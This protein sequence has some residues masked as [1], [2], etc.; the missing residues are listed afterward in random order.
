MHAS[1]QRWLPL[2]PCLI[3]LCLF[4]IIPAQAGIYTDSYSIDAKSGRM[5]THIKPARASSRVGQ[6][7]DNRNATIWS[8]RLLTY[9]NRAAAE[10]L[11]ARLTKKGF[12]S[13]VVAKAGGSYQVQITGLKSSG[14]AIAYRR[15]LLVET[16]IL[17][18]HIH[19]ASKTY[20]D[21]KRPVL[22]KKQLVSKPAQMKHSPFQVNRRASNAPPVQPQQKK[23]LKAP[24]IP[25]TEAIILH[26]TLNGADVGNHFI[27]QRADGDFL[28]TK[29]MLKKIGLKNIPLPQV[30]DNTPLSL[31][32]IHA[33]MSYKMDAQSG[34]LALMVNPSLLP[35]TDKRLML[36]KPSHAEFIQD[37]ALFLNY[38]IGYQ[39]S[40]AAPGVISA[41]FELG[42]N[43]KSVSLV[44]N[45]IYQQ[46][47]QLQRTQ[48]QLVY[49][50][51]D[52]LQRWMA[53]DIFA[54]SGDRIGGAEIG[55]ISLSRNYGLKPD[56]F[57]A[58]PLQL[59][60]MLT[61]ASEVEVL[62]DG[63]SIYKARFPAGKL[64][65]SNIPYYRSGSSNA[66][67]I[68]RDAFGR[69]TTYNESIYTS[70]SLLAPGFSRYNYAIGLE[71]QRNASGQLQ[72][73]KKA[74]LFASHQYGLSNWLTPGFGLET[75]G[76][77]AR[78]G[79]TASLLLGNYGQL[80]VV[81]A[82]SRRLGVRGSMVY[83][84]YNYTG[85]GIF[86][87]NLFFTSQTADYGGILDP[88]TATAKL[89]WNAGAGLS[90]ALGIWGSATVRWSKQMD[91]Q[92]QQSQSGSLLLSSTNLPASISLTTQ[93]TRTW[94]ANQAVDNQT[95]ISLGRY[96][97][98]GIFLTANYNRHNRDNTFGIQI[99]YSPPLGEGFGY[100]SSI[101]S[102]PNGEPV[103]NTRLQYRNQYGE[104]TASHGGT[105][106][107]GTYD[108]QLSSALLLA[109]GGLHVSRPIRDSF[110]LVRVNGIDHVN[111]RVHH[112]DIGETDANGE[113]VV[114]YIYS[115]T[116][117][118][119]SIDPS[120]IPLGYKIDTT[121]KT[122]T[123]SY[124]GGGIVEFNVI[125]MQTIEGKA[126]YRRNGKLIPAQYSAIE[127]DD[128]KT[129]KTSIIG[130]GSLLYLENIKAGTYSARLYNEQTS[131]RFNLVIPES[132]R[133]INDIG[134]VV[135]ELKP[136]T[137]T[138]KTDTK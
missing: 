132:D 95:D 125:K 33:W 73:G 26:V 17:P 78:G 130:Y 7:D 35:V 106:K 127:I 11:Q 86:S 87:P 136:K 83:A 3:G 50:N 21:M 137:A 113:I 121:S 5:I 67:L 31:K 116:N 77:N 16:N 54:S 9:N 68:V 45:F 28:I 90:A 25:A 60:T 118:S 42:M 79:I 98:N 80:D 30:D 69:E 8:V 70:N 111:V 53:G 82:A 24:S 133:M 22:P 97:D 58:P 36:R 20:A 51:R 40:F 138:S 84:N 18:E 119:I 19:I 76:N 13:Q 122:V 103:D 44:N 109:G 126:Y 135:C 49:D 124:R 59:S 72:Y 71:Q 117:N 62:I 94:T 57:T 120:V 39:K 110:A 64:N 56:L 2:G 12:P 134:D 43:V 123:S 4:S 41:P 29:K 105:A 23:P 104:I 112:Q 27:T 128:G 81:T 61:T 88:L 66:E 32:S 38:N 92:H 129:K 93:L 14:Q 10:A 47:Q 65:L 101:N 114:P 100:S 85:T 89:R 15:S 34:Y 63:Q 131:C 55:G 102:S 1:W 37:T 48:T 91:F 99:Q 75:D 108:V 107:I 74:L 6:V 52:S 46:N 96:F 115:Y